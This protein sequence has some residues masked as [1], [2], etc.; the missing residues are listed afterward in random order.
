MIRLAA[1]YIEEHEYL[2]DSS[3]S[4]NLGGAYTYSFSKKNDEILI[5]RKVNSQYISDFYNLDDRHNNLNLISVVVGQ[6]GAGKSSL[7]DVIR[8]TYVEHN[9]SLPH[10]KTLLLFEKEGIDFPLLGRCD[11]SGAKLKLLKSDKFYDTLN[12]KDLF[13]EPLPEKHQ[14]IYYSP[15]LDF[16]FNPNF[17]EVDSHDISTDKIIAK[18][19]SELSEME[20]NDSG[21]AYQ[22]N[23]ELLFKNSLR[24]IE[25][26]SSDLIRENKVFRNL[27]RLPNHQNIQLTFRGYKDRDEQDWNTPTAFRT[28]LNDVKNKIEQELKEWHTKREFDDNNNVINQLEIN[29]YIL[30]RNIL[31][32]IISLL[33]RQMERNNQYLSDS[34]FNYDFFKK[35]IAEIDSDPNLDDSQ[36]VNYLL[37]FISLCELGQGISNKSKNQKAFDSNKFQSLIDTIY[38]VIDKS[39]SEQEVSNVSLFCSTDDAIKILSSQKEFLTDLYLYYYKLRSDKDK[40]ILSDRDRISG[41]INYMPFNTPLSSGENALL[42]LFSRLYTFINDQFVSSKFLKAKDHYILILDEGDAGFHPTWKKKFIYALCRTLP[43]IMN[44]I[45][46]NPSFQIIITTHDQLTLSDLP[47][48]NVVYIER[49]TYDDLPR[50]LRNGEKKRPTKTFGANVTD[51]LADSFFMD[52]SLMGDFAHHKIKSTIDW[53]NSEEMEGSKKYRS[54]INF[55]DEPILQ[56]KLAEMYDEKMQTK[57]EVQVIDKQ[58]MHLEQLRKKLKK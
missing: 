38:E 47:N 9:Y 21:W 37:L 15:H 36:S 25:F 31:K 2:F 19:L 50:V 3:Q 1:V 52:G 4:F 57:L 20:S 43:P 45:P 33:Y 7:M 55:I 40:V 29:Q 46:S 41:F 27:F 8:S 17:D 30:K 48:N 44:E 58:I 6:N 49:E 34:N 35:K 51:L 12:G 13:E 54:I 11:F 16:K 14:S 26:M 23:Q 24:Q 22:P 5:T 56:R 10:N 53:L 28:P 39:D 32:Q 18:D 42:N